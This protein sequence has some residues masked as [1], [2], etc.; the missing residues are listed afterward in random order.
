MGAVV[1]A[2]W[3][4]AAYCLH[5]R[6]ILWSLAPLAIG[7]GLVFTLAWLYWERSV[8]TV[9]AALDQLALLAAFMQWLDSVGAQAI[10]ALLAPMI[11]VALVVPLV[12]LASLLLVALLMTPLLVA[13]VARRRFPALERKRGASWWAGAAWALLCT[14]AALVALVASIPLWFVPPLVLLLP[15]LIWGWLTYRVFAFDALASHASAAERRQIM[16]EQRWPLLT[17][18]IVSGY[19]SAA[20]SMVWVVSATTL[21]FAPLLV[22]VSVWLYTLAFA[23]AGCWFAHFGLAALERLRKAQAAAAAPAAAPPLELEAPR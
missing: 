1:D 17:M 5:P 2:F 15:P 21:I 18:G 9:R 11:V 23:F 4:A 16:R 6:V 8:A 10:H 19:V 3:R 14:A 13:L 20:P 7:G 12:V 22:L